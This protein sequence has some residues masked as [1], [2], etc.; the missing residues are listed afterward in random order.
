[1]VKTVFQIWEKREELRFDPPRINK[2]QDF[3]FVQ[4]KFP[5]GTPE[6]VVAKRPAPMPKGFDLCICTHGSAVGR[7]YTEN[8][9]DKKGV[10]LSTRTHRFI[11]SNIDKTEL[12]SRLALLDFD[13]VTKYT[14]G[15][16]CV[17]TSEIVDLYNEAHN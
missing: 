17:A 4:A 16:T 1:M 15:A 3:S 2:H 14:T 10:P 5:S 9:V 11:K 6:E 7:I 8:F 12:A 13:S